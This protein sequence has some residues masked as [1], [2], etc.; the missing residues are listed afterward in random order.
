MK[1]RKNSQ[2]ELEQ[3]LAR[4]LADY[5]NLLK[6]IEREKEEVIRRATKDFV[7]ELLPIVDELERAQAHLKDEGFK[8]ALDHLFK[9]LATNEVE[10]IEIKKGDKFDSSLH[11]AIEVEE[12]GKEGVISEVLDPGY[13]WRDGRVIRPARVRVYGESP[14]KKEELEQELGRG[15]YV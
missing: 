10:K 1:K 12:G 15:D 7:E 2:D 5:D 3:R 13:V 6:R 14:E 8:I 11:A 9:V 4:A